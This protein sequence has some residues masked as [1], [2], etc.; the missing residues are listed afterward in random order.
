V[1]PR[2]LVAILRLLSVVNQR[3][4]YVARSPLIMAKFAAG[5]VQCRDGS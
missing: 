1:A 5:D 2:L 3:V 4:Y